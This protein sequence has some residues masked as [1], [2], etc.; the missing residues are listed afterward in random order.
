MTR[1]ETFEPREWYDAIEALGALHKAEVE[2][3]VTPLP[4][5]AHRGIYDTLHEAGMLV[6]VGVFDGDAM[7][8]YAIATI[9]PNPHYDT[10]TA[11]HDVFFLHPDYRKPR[12]ALRMIEALEAE[13]KARGATLFCWHT[14]IGGSFEKLVR[15]RAKSYYIMY[16]KEL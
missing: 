10:I 15:L 3:D 8:G 6:P 12:L 7:V 4:P 9:S 1:I 5:V 14:P 11:Q 16:F 2:A 13:C